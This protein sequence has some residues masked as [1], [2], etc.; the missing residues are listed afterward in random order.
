MIAD[1]WMEI[2]SFRLLTL[3]TAWKI[4]Q[5]NDYKRCGPTSPR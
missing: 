1:S 4:D 2:E 5:Y 3:Q